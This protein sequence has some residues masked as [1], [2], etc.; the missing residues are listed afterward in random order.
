MIKC[1]TELQL[2]Q[3]EPQ[4]IHAK[5]KEKKQREWKQEPTNQTN[6]N[7]ART[8]YPF[9]TIEPTHNVTMKLNIFLDTVAV[10]FKVDITGGKE[11]LPSCGALCS[12]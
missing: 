2:I 5:P 10:P 1:N 8:V 7:R 12:I 4:I 11:C 3:L 9:N 6:K